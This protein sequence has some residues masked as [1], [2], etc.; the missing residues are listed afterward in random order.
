[1]YFS[2][3][4]PTYNSSKF[5]EKTLNCIFLQKYKKFEIIFSDDGSKD[6]TV[7]ILE[8]YKSKF[9]KLGIEVKIIQNN[10][11]GP[12]HARN[13]GLKLAKYE[14]ISFLDS[15]DL[16]HEEKLFKVFSSLEKNGELNCILHRQFFVGLNNKVK[17]YDFDKYFDEN[18]PVKK[19]LYKNN[20]FAMSAVTIKK[21][22]IEEVQGFNEKYE[23]AQDFDLWLRIG[24]RFKLIILPEYLGSYRE[25]DGNITSRPYQKRI[26]NVLKI[27]IKNRSDVNNSDLFVAIFKSL[28]NKEWIRKYF[29]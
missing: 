21:R 18:I 15:D 4:C 24:N 17:N 22:L 14:W 3:I 28:F 12:G 27:L 11:G 1:M 6:D 2:I 16:W 7:Q 25:R 29:K 8:D 13:Q 23:N 19:Q 5:L 9:Q 26:L 20:F 10:H